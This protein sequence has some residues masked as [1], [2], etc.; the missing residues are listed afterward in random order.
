MAQ[1][2]AE[3]HA[4][5]APTRDELVAFTERVAVGNATNDEVATFGQWFRKKA[6]PD[7]AKAVGSMLLE[8]TSS[9]VAAIIQKTMM[10]S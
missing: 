10:G 3:I 5:D 2:Q 4:L 7:A 8:V 1:M 9:V 6:G